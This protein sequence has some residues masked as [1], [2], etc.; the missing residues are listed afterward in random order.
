MGISS[1]IYREDSWRDQ[2]SLYP[3]ADSHV[4]NEQY[5][6]VVFD[7]AQILPCHVIHLDLG[8]EIAKYFEDIPDN[9]PE[10]PRV[11]LEQERRDKKTEERL[12]PRF[13]APGDKQRVKETLI[14][15]AGKYFSYAYGPVSGSKFIIEDV[16]EVDEDGEDYGE[17]QE[18]RVEGIKGE[19]DIWKRDNDTSFVV[20]ETGEGLEDEDVSGEN[21]KVKVMEDEVGEDRGRSLWARGAKGKSQFDEYYDARTAKSKRVE[22][23]N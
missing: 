17:Y 12:N 18:E 8:R 15:K 23:P 6:Y 11:W 3:G 7:Q 9:I 13:M 21:N 4:A 14:A 2:S 5:E 10:N 19:N 22:R 1:N 16:G 20:E